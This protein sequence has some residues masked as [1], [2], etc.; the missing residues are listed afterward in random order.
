[1]IFNF[2]QASYSQSYESLFNPVCIESMFVQSDEYIQGEDFAIYSPIKIDMLSIV[3][4]KLEQFRSVSGEQWENSGYKQPLNETFY[5]AT[6]FLNSIP[7]LYLY[8][9]AT[10]NIEPTPYGTFIL[11]FMNNQN[12]VSI[13]IGREKVGFFTKF[14]NKENMKSDGL[15]FKGDDVPKEVFAAFKEMVS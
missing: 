6:H 12:K 10:E 2:Q 15:I 4:N 11:D 13:E 5:N 1:M 3:L 14:T 8:S 7:D 9:L